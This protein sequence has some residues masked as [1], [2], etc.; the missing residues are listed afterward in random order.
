MAARR[1]GSRAPVARSRR[2][3]LDGVTALDVPLG[4]RVMVVSDLLL[5]PTATA[6]PRRRDR[7]AGP[8]PRHVG[9]PRHPGHRRQPVRPHR[10]RTTVRRPAAAL[11]AHP[12]WPRLHPVPRR[13]RAAGRAPA[14]RPTSPR[15][16][17]GDRGPGARPM[18]A[19]AAA[20]S[21]ISGRSTSTSTP[22][23]GP[24][25]PGRA[26]RRV[27][28]PPPT[29]PRPAGVRTPRPP[30]PAAAH[31]TWRTVAPGPAESRGRPVAGGRRPPERPVRAVPLRRL[32]HPLPPVR[33]LRLVAARPLRSSPCCCGSA[34]H[35]VAPRPPRHGLPGRALRHAHTADLG[36]QLVVGPG[37]AVVVIAVMAVVLGLLSRRMWSDPRGRRPRGRPATRRRPTTP[38]ATTPAG[39]SAQ[40]YA[41]LITAATFQP[42]LTHLGIGFYANV[43]AT[44]EV[45]A[46]HRGR[47]GLPPVFLAQPVGELGRARDRGRAARPPPARP[48]R[49][50]P[51]QPARGARH[52][53]PGRA[54]RS[55]RAGGLLPDR[56]TRGRPPPTC[57]RP[58]G[59]PAGCGDGRAGAILLAGVIDLLDADHPAAARPA[60]PGAGVPAAAGQRGGRGPG[61]RGRPRPD[62]P[63][64]GHPAR[65]AAGMAGR[66]R[67]SSPAPSSS[68]WW[69]APTSRSR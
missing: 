39:W 8:G 35:P 66:R 44:A 46:E 5:T 10:R 22:A 68:T 34:R 4:R 14:R 24:G 17:N 37:A 56:A 59:A 2:P 48:Q 25:G 3:E 67:S 31:G 27:H 64:P 62:R 19:L 26:R 20:A 6:P 33:P 12:R 18:R 23:P 47:L 52:P 58:T 41:G 60:P 61:G 38:P 65:P 42:E 30:T 1:R 13:G 53:G 55:T 11:D 32:A 21:S 40:G 63:R 57:A 29:A 49:P 51:A 54:A 16:V 7:R 36:D 50:A 28:G 45:V 43:G 69:P 9:R 15:L